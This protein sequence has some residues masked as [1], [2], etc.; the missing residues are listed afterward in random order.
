MTSHFAANLIV[1]AGRLRQA[2]LPIGTDR[3]LTLIEALRLID[4]ASKDDMTAACRAV[5]VQRR[6]DI[7]AFNQVFERFR[8]TPQPDHGGDEGQPQEDV[9]E[10]QPED[11]EQ[12]PAVEPAPGT[13]ADL[14]RGAGR[15]AEGWAHAAEAPGDRAGSRPERKAG[16]C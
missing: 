5:L 12:V 4:L 6:E 9:R 11:G 15:R 10:G 2:G 3:I 16:A 14:A 13:L 7:A 1:L 8:F